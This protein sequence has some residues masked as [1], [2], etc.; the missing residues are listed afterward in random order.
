M[1]PISVFSER[2]AAQDAASFTTLASAFDDV[3]AVA[4]SITFRNSDITAVS[5][6]TF[7]HLTAV[8]GSVEF[9][10]N[11][12]LRS[13]RGFRALAEVGAGVALGSDNAA[14]EDVVFAALHHVRGAVAAGGPKLARVGLPKLAHA[15]G[16]NVCTV[17]GTLSFPWLR[18][19]GTLTLGPVCQT[20]EG[21]HIPVL[22]SAGTI[23]L[24]SDYTVRLRSFCNGRSQNAGMGIPGQTPSAFTA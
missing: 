5:N 3:V 8:S 7:P 2:V 17:R 16:I 19:V 18:T 11:K 14:L 20:G 21:L 6:A 10:R 4:G 1:A 24:G 22:A 13:V 9:A 15:G 12:V 23:T